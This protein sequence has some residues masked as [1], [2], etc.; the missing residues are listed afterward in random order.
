[1]APYLLLRLRG[2]R[3]SQDRRRKQR[4]GMVDTWSSWGLRGHG[5][6]ELPVRGDV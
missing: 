4:R 6:D 3:S 5:S 1:M 2:E